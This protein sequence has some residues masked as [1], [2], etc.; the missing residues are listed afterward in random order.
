MTNFGQGMS[1][2][3]KKWSKMT[4]FPKLLTSVDHW[5]NTKVNFL[6]HLNHRRLIA[7]KFLSG[8][9]ILDLEWPPANQMNQMR[10]IRLCF[11]RSELWNESILRIWN[12]LPKIIKKNVPRPATKIK[13]LETRLLSWKTGPSKKWCCQVNIGVSRLLVMFPS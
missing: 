6:N 9:V 1:N 2:F 7:T 10:F 13:N 11:S 8:D 4:D 5:N 3:G 12:F